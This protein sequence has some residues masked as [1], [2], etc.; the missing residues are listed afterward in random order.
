MNM[1]QMPVTCGAYFS[2]GH[3]T[4]VIVVNVAI[5]ISSNV[6]YRIVRVGTVGGII[7][8][9]LLKF[10]FLCMAFNFTCRIGCQC[11]ISL[12]SWAGKLYYSVEDYKSTPT[13]K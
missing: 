9:L 3:S 8:K 2:L 7:G 5:A 4:I 10:G 6:Y 12:H 1:G 13:G 11:R